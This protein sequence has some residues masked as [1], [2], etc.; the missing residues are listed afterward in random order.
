M[1][2]IKKLTVAKNHKPFNPRSE[3][4]KKFLAQHLAKIKQIQ[5]AHPYLDLSEELNFFSN[6]SNKA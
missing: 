1:G 5:L 2:E 6:A 4:H 3:M